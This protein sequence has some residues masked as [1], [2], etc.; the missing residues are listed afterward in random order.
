[1][2]VSTSF[3]VW[4]S[5]LIAFARPQA[6]LHN[7]LCNRLLLRLRRANMELE[8]HGFLSVQVPVPERA[9]DTD[10]SGVALADIRSA[11][12]TLPGT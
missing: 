7:T 10:S 5:K 2:Y 11:W 6:A 8:E 4:L 12:S 1:M 3:Q 9:S